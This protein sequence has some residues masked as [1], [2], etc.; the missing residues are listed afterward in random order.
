MLLGD[1]KAF[2]IGLN[3][4]GQIRQTQLCHLILSYF[5]IENNN[6]NRH[7]NSDNSLIDTEE[8]LNLEVEEK[9]IILSESTIYQINPMINMG[10]VS[11]YDFA[12]R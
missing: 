7:Q 2:D 11:P 12:E 6:A 1:P 4:Q 9:E 8:K 3:T 5:E 10:D